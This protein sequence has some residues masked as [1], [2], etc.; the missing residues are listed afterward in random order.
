MTGEAVEEGMD[1]GRERNSKKAKGNTGSE[2]W[3]SGTPSFVASS[4][5]NPGPPFSS[6]IPRSCDSERRSCV[7]EAKAKVK[8]VQTHT[9]TVSRV[10]VIHS[11]VPV[12]VVQ[13][14]LLS[15]FLSSHL[16]CLHPALYTHR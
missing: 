9:L 3:R 8:V 5:A 16:D 2:E 11:P 14:R 7:Q 6:L 15:L 4:C 13:H 12:A 10:C 1:G